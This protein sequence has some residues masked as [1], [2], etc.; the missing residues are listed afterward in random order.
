MTGSRKSNGSSVAIMAAARRFTRR[1]LL[2][3]TAAA[4]AVAAMGPWIV[5][6]S[7]LILGR[8][9]HSGLVG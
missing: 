6:G 3:G 4:G 2:K 8:A 7:T 5:R 9:Q 1:T